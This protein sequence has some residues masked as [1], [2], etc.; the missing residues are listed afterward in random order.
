MNSS[1]PQ[2]GSIP[3]HLCNH[4]SHLS[5]PLGRSVY[6]VSGT[7]GRSLTFSEAPFCLW[8]K[9]ASCRGY[10]GRAHC[11]SQR[12]LTSSQK[13]SYLLLIS[14]VVFLLLEYFSYVEPAPQE[15]APWGICPRYFYCSYQSD[16]P[17]PTNSWLTQM[18]NS[19]HSSIDQFRNSRWKQKGLGQGP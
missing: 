18:G 2:L 5:F 12:L 19:I 16:A 15:H 11:L 1:Y 17:D 6:H 10:T 8:C 4:T 3:A 14:A 7:V 9:Y 13:D